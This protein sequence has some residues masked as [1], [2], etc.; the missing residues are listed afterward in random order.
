MDDL[1]SRQ[2]AIDAVRGS[3][4]AQNHIKNLP[5]VKPQKVGRW[6]FFERREPQYDLVGVKT[7]AVAY[8]CSE[9]GF[10]HTVIEDF[11]HYAYCPNCGAKM[12][13]GDVDADCN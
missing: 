10:I 4:W 12:E 3:I 13:R 5:S 11:G 2:A 7:W 1:I 9:C 8:K 6:D